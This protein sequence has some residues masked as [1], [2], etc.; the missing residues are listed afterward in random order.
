[1]F[2]N[3]ISLRTVRGPVSTTDRGPL[4]VEVELSYVGG[5]NIRALGSVLPGRL[6]EFDPVLRTGKFVHPMKL[7][8][9]LNKLI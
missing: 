5:A 1:M 2:R 4:Y 9:V 7:R 6:P 3:L 8:I